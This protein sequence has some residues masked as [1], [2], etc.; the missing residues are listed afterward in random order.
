MQ[1]IGSERNGIF[2]PA[3]KAANI[4]AGS[5][6]LCNQC[7]LPAANQDCPAGG[8]N[9]GWERTHGAANVENGLCFHLANQLEQFAANWRDS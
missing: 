4:K 5:V 1:K 3:A 8:H 2:I 7:T 6:P 9:H